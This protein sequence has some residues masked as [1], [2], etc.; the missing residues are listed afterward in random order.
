MLVTVLKQSACCIASCSMWLHAD[1][2]IVKQCASCCHCKRL[3]CLIDCLLA[4]LMI[5]YLMDQLIACL[6]PLRAWWWLT[7]PLGAGL[8]Q[9][10]SACKEVITEPTN[11]SGEVFDGAIKSYRW[12]VAYFKTRQ[13]E[14]KKKNAKQY[15]SAMQ[16]CFC[17][18]D[19]SN[20]DT[21]CLAKAVFLVE[22]LALG[23]SHFDISL[24]KKACI[25]ML[26]GAPISYRICIGSLIGGSKV[27]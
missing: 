14:A 12:A 25:P 27:I 19:S 17:C 2:S 8:W 13:N 7:M 10:L 3:L 26:M 11:V 23:T 20:P 1:V 9:Q 6:M 4:C 15:K 22:G 21:P 18:V 16:L 5:V 24:R